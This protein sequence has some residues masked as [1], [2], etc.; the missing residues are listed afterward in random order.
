MEAT[1]PFVFDPRPGI[2][3]DSAY[4]QSL[5]MT[6]KALERSDSDNPA[7]NTHSLYG[8]LNGLRCGGARLELTNGKLR[9]LAGDWGEEYG[10]WREHY[11][12]PHAETLR[13]LLGNIGM[14]LAREKR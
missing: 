9:L 12:L 10:Y 13:R 14:M 7:D 1:D 3:A 2:S 11:L 4:W 6:T 8:A 5:L